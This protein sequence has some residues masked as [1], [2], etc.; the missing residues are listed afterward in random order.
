MEKLEKKNYIENKYRKILNYLYKKIIKLSIGFPIWKSG[1]LDF[2]E[3]H[4]LVLASLVIVV[5][6]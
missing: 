1:K 3:E 5:P 2:F 6:L 4:C